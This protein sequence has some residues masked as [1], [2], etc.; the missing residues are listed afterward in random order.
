M[1]PCLGPPPSLLHCLSIIMTLAV[2]VGGRYENFEP[3]MRHARASGFCP[4]LPLGKV[5]GERPMWG[6]G[7]LQGFKSVFMESHSLPG[8]FCSKSSHLFLRAA[9][10]SL[11][12]KEG[13][14]LENQLQLHQMACCSSKIS[15]KM[16]Q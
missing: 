11:K 7:V 1:P 10:A 9:L 13:L 5:P 15:P 6:R 16:I 3:F 8:F 14:R 12:D 4:L 2:G